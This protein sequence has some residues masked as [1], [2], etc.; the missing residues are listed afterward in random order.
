M[1]VWNYRCLS[2]LKSLRYSQ[3]IS[4]KTKG[5]TADGK[6]IT[7]PAPFD[8]TAN[9]NEQPPRLPLRKMLNGKRSFKVVNHVKLAT[10][11]L[12][13]YHD[14]YD[15]GRRHACGSRRLASMGGCK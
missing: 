2:E 4:L 3:E 12:W 9:K 7:M 13:K 6:G 15:L 5:T 1:L 10:N 14:F 11:N 8:I